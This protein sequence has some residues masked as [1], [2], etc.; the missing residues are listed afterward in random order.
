[1]AGYA[2]SRRLS[3]PSSGPDDLLTGWQ[4][5]DE[6]LSGN[7]RSKLA[8]AEKAA[9]THPQYSINAT[10]LREIQ[11]KELTAT[12]IEVIYERLTTLYA[13]TTRMNNVW[14]CLDNNI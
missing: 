8:E 4:T 10:S 9:E 5:A 14:K 12:E 3:E 13:I 11:P 2:T 6:Y 7:V 1:M